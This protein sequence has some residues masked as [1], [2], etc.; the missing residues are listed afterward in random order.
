TAATSN[1][2]DDFLLEEVIPADAVIHTEPAQDIKSADDE[3]SLA[4][5][6]LELELA[7]EMLA[8]ALTEDKAPVQTSAHAIAPD[9]IAQDVNTQNLMPQ[10][11]LKIPE[12][13]L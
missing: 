6:E 4:A 1:S 11:I 2:S 10:D 9:V 12:Q 3:F 8:Q 13:V 7:Q 5:P